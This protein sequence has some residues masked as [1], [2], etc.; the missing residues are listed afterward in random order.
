MN[1]TK[2]WN[3][4]RKMKNVPATLYLEP[5]KFV[6]SRIFLIKFGDFVK[7]WILVKFE[8]LNPKI[9]KF[10][11]L[12]PNTK[13]SNLD[14]KFLNFDDF[15]YKFEENFAEIDKI[16]DIS[17]FEILNPKI[18]N[19]KSLTLKSKIFNFDKIWQKSKF[20]HGG[21]SQLC[22][23][24][25]IRKSKFSKICLNVG[26]FNFLSKHFQIANLKHCINYSRLKRAN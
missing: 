18:Q 15:C 23:F 10:E 25:K 19:L 9:S 14:T 4:E 7:F 26:I 20:R 8:I 3:F 5:T 22:D 17:K 16:G 6:I 12:N 2:N 1:W 11:I 21:L 13:I 24:N